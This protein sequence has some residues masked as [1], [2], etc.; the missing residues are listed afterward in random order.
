V[1]HVEPIENRYYA[2]Q[3]HLTAESYIA[4]PDH[5]EDGDDDDVDDDEEIIVQEEDDDDDDDGEAGN[6]EQ[7]WKDVHHVH[8]HDNHRSY[9]EDDD[10]V[11]APPEENGTRGER[12]GQEHGLAAVKTE[13]LQMNWGL[14]SAHKLSIAEMVEVMKQEME[15]VQRMENVDERDTDEYLET[16]QA[17]LSAKSI[18]VTNLR[19]EL[20]AFREFRTEQRLYH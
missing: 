2:S 8:G 15:L 20:H 3:A 17:I 7:E 11:S 10:N 4:D 12:P 18:A 14:L 19:Q 16:L 13:E 9:L 1:Y 5:L 6:D